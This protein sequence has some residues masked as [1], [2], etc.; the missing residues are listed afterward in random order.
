MRRLLGAA[1]LVGLVFGCDDGDDG[2]TPT[3]DAAVTD[4]ALTDAATS[5]ATVAPDATSSDAALSLDAMP[6]AV[7]TADAAVDAAPMVDAAPDVDPAALDPQAD[8]PFR[9]GYRAFDVTYTPPGQDAERTVTVNLWYPTWAMAGGDPPRYAGIQIDRLVF[10][11]AP[12]A[13]SAHADGY[14][15]MI[16][17]HG[18]RGYGGDSAYLARRMASHG[19]VFVAPDHTGNTLRDVAGEDRFAHYVHRPADLSA[20]L[21]ALAALPAED[22]LA[23]SLVTGRVV[24]VGHS[25]GTYTMFALAGATLD[26]DV[27][28]TRCAEGGFDGPCEPSTRAAFAAGLGDPRVVGVVPLAGGFRTNFFGATGQ[29]TVAVPVLWMTGSADPQGVEDQLA[30]FAGH[31]VLWVDLEGGCHLTF[32][33]GSCATLPMGEGHAIVQA[34]VGAFGRSVVVGDEGAAVAGI[35]DGSVGVSERVEVRRAPEE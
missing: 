2:A 6:D 11:D 23:G 14:P 17:S 5:D 15:V 20:T 12:P 22:P 8:G 34:F 35:L 33:L 27:L 16:Y 28:D 4:A 21:D 3:S 18:D 31:D 19:W 30:L 26:L 7:V 32:T 25:R 24:A 10:T 9:V 1:L 13:A 29:D